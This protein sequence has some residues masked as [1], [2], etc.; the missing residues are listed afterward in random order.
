MIKIIILTFQ[1]LLLFGCE[2]NF[3]PQIQSLTA[4]PNPVT[5]GE[6]VQLHCIAIDDDEPNLLK[7]EYLDYT[8]YAAFGN[9]TINNIPEKATWIAPLDTGKYSISCEVSDQYNGA[10]IITLE[11]KVQ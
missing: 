8:W 5:A 11:I 7:N 9:I 6:S 3:E 1:L 2:N 10:D 4:E